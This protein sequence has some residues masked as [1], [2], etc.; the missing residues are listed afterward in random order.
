MPLLTRGT[1]LVV[2]TH[3]AGKL[4]E[5]QALIAPYG[6][7]A[8]SAG[9]LG[10]P[11]PAETGHMF[12]ENAAIKAHA[13]ARAS[14][15]IAL[16]DDSGMCADALDG[17]P[18]LFT[19][20][21]STRSA[22]GARDFIPAMER[23]ERELQ[24]RGATIPEQRR[25]R[26]V[27]AL[28]LAWPPSASGAGKQLLFEGRA[29]GTL[30]WPMRGTKGFGYDPMF[31]PDVQPPRPAGTQPLTFAEMDP[32]EKMRIDHRSRAFEKFAAACLV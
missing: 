32:Q 14:G 15:L 26:F 20:D 13:A 4:A 17:A 23:T 30:V 31:V 8:I 5:I 2:A 11:E 12:A 29:F 22:D 6:L 1:R 28:V 10:L 7:E 27:S 3:N 24:L 9:A 18:G 16:A 21:W 19:A 25:A